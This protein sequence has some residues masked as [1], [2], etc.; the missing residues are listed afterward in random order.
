MNLFLMRLNFFVDLQKGYKDVFLMVKRIDSGIKVFLEEINGG[1]GE[2]VQF[3]CLSF[4][5]NLDRCEFVQ[6]GVLGGVILRI[7]LGF[8]YL[9]VIVLIF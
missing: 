8:N 7:V 4:G 5:L 9:V 1:Y 2:G 3:L 6:I